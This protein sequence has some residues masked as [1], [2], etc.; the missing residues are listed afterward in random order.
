ME[1]QRLLSVDGA[2]RYRRASITRSGARD[3]AAAARRADPGGGLRR[4]FLLGLGVSH[5]RQVELRGQPDERRW[6]DAVVPD[7]D[8]R[9]VYDGTEAGRA[10]AAPAA[11]LLP[12]HA[13]VSPARARRRAIRT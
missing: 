12:R 9:G 6:P 13:A 10:G 3:A 5:P 11:A 2:R 8:G 4:R 1:Q 7:G